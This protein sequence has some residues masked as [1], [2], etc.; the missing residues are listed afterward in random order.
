MLFSWNIHLMWLWFYLRRSISFEI[1]EHGYAIYFGPKNKENQSVPVILYPHGGPHGCS[2]IA[3]SPVWQ[4][5]SRLGET[6][7]CFYQNFH[8]QQIDKLINWLYFSGL[9]VLIINYRGSTGCGKD[10][11]DAL[12]G[13]VGSLDVKD[14]YV[15]LQNSFDKFPWLDPKNVL[16]FGGSHGGFIVT[17]LSSQYPVSVNNLTYLKWRCSKRKGCT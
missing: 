1:I 4:L 8:R 10:F 16:L 12:L 3:F 7:L 11:L 9:A 17:H 13:H 15:A 2:S 5:F 14:C 6:S